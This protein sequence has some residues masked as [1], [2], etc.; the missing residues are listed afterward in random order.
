VDDLRIFLNRYKQL[1]ES[2]DIFLFRNLSRKGIGFFIS[3]GFYPDFIIWVKNGNRQNMIFVDPKGIRNI[4]NFNDD[5]IQLC[6]SYIKEIEN[7][8]REELKK[9]GESANLILDAFIISVSPYNDI[10][11]T[12]GEG[13]YTKEEFEKHNIFFQEDYAYIRKIFKKIGVIKK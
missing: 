10:K 6:V 9:R 2:T 1:L 7:K 3:S 12:F 4:G 8:V 5:K 11:P 13:K